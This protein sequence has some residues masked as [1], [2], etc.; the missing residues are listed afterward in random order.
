MKK[1]KEVSIP[2]VAGSEVQEVDEN[3]VVQLWHRAEQIYNIIFT[4]TINNPQDYK[5]AL[6]YLLSLS[7]I[8][9]ELDKKRQ[10]FTKPL[11]DQM[12]RINAYFDQY[13]K[14]IE[15]ADKILRQKIVQYRALKWEEFKQQEKEI[16]EQI[17]NELNSA[18]LP[19]VVVTPSLAKN[20][21]LSGGE[22]SF[23]VVKKWVI[24][25][26]SKLPREYLKPDD[27]KIAEAV[28]KGENIPGVKIYTEEEPQ[29]KII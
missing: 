26:E 28:K 13:L 19:P 29:V 2:Q 7:V 12:R 24:E 16:Y 20:E 9:L 4:I 18:N 21:V 22:V 17:K 10:F 11:Y 25:D 5:K 23:R 6:E 27:K 1:V 8:K 3:E 14:P 15:E